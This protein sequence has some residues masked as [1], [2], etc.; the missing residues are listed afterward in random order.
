VPFR[1]NWLAAEAGADRELAQSIAI[2]DISTSY[3]EA[4][5][6]QGRERRAE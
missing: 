4:V 6:E 3:S 1:L 2:I 5:A